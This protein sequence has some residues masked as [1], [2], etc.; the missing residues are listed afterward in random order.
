MEIVVND[1]NILID[2]YNAGL[3]P[4]CKGLG[5]DFRT[6]DV[7]MN[8]IEVKEQLEAV[9][10]L[11]AEGTL[12][13]DSLSSNQVERVFQMIREY[14]GNCN[15]SPED[16]SVMVYAKDNKCRLLTGD[17]TL[18]AKAIIENIQVSGVLYLTDLLTKASILSYAEMA[19][20]LKLLLSS[21]S[22]LPRKLIQERIDWLNK[23]L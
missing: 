3:L 18:R 4:H 20:A 9:G 23:Q 10:Q 17:K 7:V 14:E 12:T 6:L 21:N 15:L 2:L 13:V 22:R 16:I 8:E 1:T 5:L 19:E 11:V